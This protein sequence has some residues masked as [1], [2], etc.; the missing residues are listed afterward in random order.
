MTSL[1]IVLALSLALV[2]GGVVWAADYEGCPPGQVLKKVGN[3]TTA[4]TSTLTVSGGSDVRLIALTC[5]ST[6]CTATLRDLNATPAS[7][8]TDFVAADTVI[9]PGAAASATVLVPQSGFF[10]PP[11]R[12][13]TGIV[14]TGDGNVAAIGVYSCQTP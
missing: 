6:A 1:R 10:N 11:L 14:Y 2:G 9:E 5:T 7:S 3:V 13:N 8:G 12:F 4:D